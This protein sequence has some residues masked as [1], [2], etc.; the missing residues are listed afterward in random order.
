MNLLE[1]IKCIRAEYP[2]MDM[3]CKRNFVNNLICIAQ[4]IV[5]SEELLRCAIS[6]L[7]N[8]G[9]DFNKKLLEYYKGHLDEETGHHA[10]ILD[11][12]DG[13]EM[14]LNWRAAELAGVQ[15]YLI[16]HVHPAALLGYMAVLE[17]DPYPL[18]LVDELELL[19]GNKLCRTLRYHA[20][21]DLDHREDVFKMIDELPEHLENIVRENAITTV[22]RIGFAQLTNY[23]NNNG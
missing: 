5:A 14:D 12:L 20:E 3:S 11:D 23:G 18:S 7:S 8:M 13:I 21:H 2:L 15:Y 4:T 17:G 6:E 22:R 19:H 9:G 10:W 16:K 1:E